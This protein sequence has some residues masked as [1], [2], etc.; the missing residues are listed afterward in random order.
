MDHID[1][2]PDDCDV[3][4]CTNLAALQR[5]DHP[6]QVREV[7]SFASDKLLRSGFPTCALQD[8]VSDFRISCN[9]RVLDPLFSLWP[10]VEICAWFSAGMD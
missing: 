2:V 10:D 5:V 1:S 9:L 7:Q 4:G 6:R 3:R 8:C